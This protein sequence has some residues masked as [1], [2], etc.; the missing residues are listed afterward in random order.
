MQVQRAASKETADNALQAVSTEPSFPR[1][2]EDIHADCSCLETNLVR[3]EL[4]GE[5][6]YVFHNIIILC[7]TL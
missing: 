2:I 5:V 4:D 1:I 7:R 3:E 6:L